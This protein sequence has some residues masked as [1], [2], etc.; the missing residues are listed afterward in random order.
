MQRF[1][2][3][4]GGKQSSCFLRA[5]F[6]H[7]ITSGLQ[8]V[9]SHGEGDRSVTLWIYAYSSTVSFPGIPMRKLMA[10]WTWWA[11]HGLSPHADGRSEL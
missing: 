10:D 3:L 1:Q 8:R 9:W 11:G 6:H 7:L 4:R 5:A 2:R